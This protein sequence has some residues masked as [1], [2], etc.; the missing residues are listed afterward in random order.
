[1][2]KSRRPFHY[3]RNGEA[4]FNIHMCYFKFY[5]KFKK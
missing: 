5:F 2:T 3:L 4:K 1:M